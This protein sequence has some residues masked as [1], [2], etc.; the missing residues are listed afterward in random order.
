M[1]LQA[2][3]VILF[4]ALMGNFFLGSVQVYI[5]EAFPGI[6]M[7]ER[8]I[9]CDIFIQKKSYSVYI[10]IYIHTI[11]PDKW[12]FIS[13][14]SFTCCTSIKQFRKSRA[15]YEGNNLN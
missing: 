6:I 1:C 8:A 3:S 7:I 11:L 5:G 4:N 12:A 9:S 10:Y 14:M 15:S 2:S 13:I